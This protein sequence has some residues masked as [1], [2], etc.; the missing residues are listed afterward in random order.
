[1]IACEAWLLD[2]DVLSGQIG[3]GR[4]AFLEGVLDGAALT[5]FRLFR[6]S[7]GGLNVMWP[8]SLRHRREGDYEARSVLTVDE[9]DDVIRARIHAAMTA[10]VA[11]ALTMPRRDV[12]GHGR[13]PR[14]IPF[15]RVLLDCAGHQLPRRHGGHIER[16]ID[17]DRPR[18][19]AKL[20]YR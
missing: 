1:M 3:V 12:D 2:R 11:V 17:V 18:L 15:G 6:N 16:P 14:E 4:I 20:R 13:L 19:P 5:G 10:A 7:Q 9:D 8:M